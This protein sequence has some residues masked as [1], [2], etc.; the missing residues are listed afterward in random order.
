MPT[1]LPTATRRPTTLPT[2]TQ[3]TATATFTA[4]RPALARYVFPVQSDGK[5]SYGRF[6][7]DYPAADIFCPVGSVF[8]AV[9]D[10][11]VD[12][13]SRQDLWAPAVND[14]ATRGGLAV[15]IIGDDGARYYGSHLSQIADGIIPG[16]RVTAGQ[17]LGLTG[18]TGDARFT[19]PHLHFGISH[20]TTPDDWE[21]RRGEIA[22]YE[23]LRAWQRGEDVAPDLAK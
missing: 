4:T 10:G 13:V 1:S 11:V 7:H 14:G 23:Y 22:P 9:T 15:A 18:K 8:V 3:P 6:H 20:P 17:P 5:I 16:A 2:A 12:F 19:D 21:M